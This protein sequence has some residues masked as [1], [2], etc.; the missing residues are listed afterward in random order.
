MG[1]KVHSVIIT[2]NVAM[3]MSCGTSLPFLQ[4]VVKDCMSR[5]YCRTCLSAAEAGQSPLP[6]SLGHIDNSTSLAPKIVQAC[7]TVKE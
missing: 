1:L 7:A 5:D 3:F 6:L 2:C 4:Q